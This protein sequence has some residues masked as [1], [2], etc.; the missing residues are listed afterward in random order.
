MQL[1]RLRGLFYRLAIALAVTAVFFTHVKGEWRLEMVSQVERYLYD[2]RLRMALPK[3]PPKSVV[4][5]DIDEKSIAE[6]GHWP[7]S[8]DVLA[9]MLDMLFSEYGVNVGGF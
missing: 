7:W 1:K 8:R 5:V 3:E 4:I 2:A 9:K 6:L